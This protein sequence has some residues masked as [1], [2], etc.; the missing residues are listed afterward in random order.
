[1]TE[2]TEQRTSVSAKSELDQ[3]RWSVV[4]FDA[5]EGSGLT[6]DAAARLL[7]EREAAGV[8][9]LCIVTDDAAS[10]LR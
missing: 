3:P 10:R 8:Y 5:C 9:G 2:A 6:Y 1:M 4:S 7:A